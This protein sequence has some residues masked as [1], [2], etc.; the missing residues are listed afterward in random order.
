MSFVR[1]AEGE[2][3]VGQPAPWPLY[4]RDK[5]LLLARG[6]VV[7]SDRQIA[8]LAMRGLFRKVKV[9]ETVSAKP[10]PDDEMGAGAP[11]EEVRALE[12]TKLAIGDTLQL[13]AQ[14][15]GGQA[16]YYVKVIG[17]LVKKGLIVTT[18]T[19]DGRVLLMREGQS[20]VVRMF[21]GKSVY[22]FSATVFKVANVPYPH[23]HL[24]YPS[25]V[26]GLV[27]R[28]G[29]RVNVRLI[30][31]IQTAG[32]SQAATLSNLSTGGAAL[33]AK[34]KLGRK[35]DEISI[36]FRV[37]I[38]GVEQYLTLRGIIRSVMV[39]AGDGDGGEVVV[40]GVQ[41]VDVPHAEHVS[42]TA[43]VYQTLF[44]ESAES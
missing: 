4:D 6:V 41:F 19:V 30:A 42:L 21:S 10:Q 32:L 38:N 1:V 24:T 5:N 35:G 29:A 18:P 37:T 8:Q 26:R 39:E 28:S 43:F 27:V 23:L 34:V 36:K 3:R 16:R 44:E 33:Q 40:H 25:Q 9:A 12:D 11:K 14:A 31:A 2:L 7:E 22:A 17:Y 13:Q 20:F 15:E